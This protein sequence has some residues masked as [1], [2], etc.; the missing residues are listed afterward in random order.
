MNRDNIHNILVTRLRFMGD[1]ILTIPLLDALRQNYPRARISYLAES[2]YLSLLE[3]HPGVDTLLEIDRKNFARTVPVY[4]K[5]AAGAYDLAIDLFGNPRS[6]LLTRLSRARIRIG[7]DFRGR[8]HFYSHTVNNNQKKLNAIQFHLS[9]LEPLAIRF[10]TIDP[11]INI[12]PQEKAWAQEYLQRR[13]FRVNEKIIGIHPGASWPA[14]R[15]FPNRFAVLANRL[16]SRAKSQILFTMGPGEEQILE[17][18]LK[19]C[20]FTLIQPKVLTLRQLAAVLS[21]VDVFISNDCGPM[22]LAPA[23]GTPTIGLF[24]PGEP[25]IWFPYPRDLGHRFIHHD[26]D[27]S[28]CRRDFCDNPVCMQTITVDE[29]YDTAVDILRT[30][31]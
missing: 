1:I 21:Q 9:Y 22:H 19:S 2:P 29:V 15:W 28:R 16:V 27:C 10:R 20:T 25:E 14:K 26:M 3:D 13:G 6:A 31:G 7:G 11:Y 30:W 18:T 4:V 12:T 17:S 8:R 23:V 24:G 5:L